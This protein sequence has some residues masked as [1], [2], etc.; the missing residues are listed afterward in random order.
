M[1]RTG[2]DP[3]RTVAIL[4]W[5]HLFEDFIGNLGVSFDEFRTGYV[6]A[7]TPKGVKR[8]GWHEIRVEVKKP[9]PGK[10]EIRARKGYAGG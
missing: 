8:E 1:V 6:L 10:L 4:D 5:C 7:Y 3:V 9:V 2:P